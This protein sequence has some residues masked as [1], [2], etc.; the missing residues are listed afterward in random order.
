MV[1]T[2]ICDNIIIGVSDNYTDEDHS[3]NAKG[4]R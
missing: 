1:C 4:N 2:Y 3:R